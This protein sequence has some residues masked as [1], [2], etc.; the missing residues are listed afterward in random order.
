MSHVNLVFKLN[1]VAALCLVA[2]AAPPE[3][4]DEW[5]TLTTQASEAYSR[6]AYAESETLYESALM[7]ARKLAAE[8][9][10]LAPP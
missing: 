5:I 4:V 8:D 9:D 2:A 7:I 1:W 3:N 10:R 6:G